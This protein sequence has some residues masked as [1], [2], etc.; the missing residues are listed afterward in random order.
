LIEPSVAENYLARL[1]SIMKR[2]NALITARRKN[3]SQVKEDTSEYLH[4][5]EPDEEDN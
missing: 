2:L 4:W 1:T 5:L 3:T